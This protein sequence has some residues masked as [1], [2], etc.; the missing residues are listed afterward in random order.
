MSTERT[1]AKRAAAQRR[2]ADKRAAEKRAEDAARRRRRAVVGAVVAG[3]V[4]VVA[5][6]VVVIVQM[7][8]T[9]TSADGP[10]PAGLVADGTAFAVGPDGVP[11]VDVY[12]DFICP[13]CG[14]FAAL[15]GSTLASLAEDGA[16][17]VRYRPIAFLDRFSTD[18]YSTRALNAAAVVADAAGTEAF[19]RFHDALFAQ[20]PAEGGPGLSDDTLIE[21]ADDAGATGDDVA[22]AIRNLRFGDWVEQVTDAASKAGVNGTPTVLVDGEVLEDRSPQ[23]LTDAVAAAG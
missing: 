2:I 3:V 8:R 21:L 15:S 11:V 16:A 22:E 23:G 18:D 6:L 19:L 7:Q 14:Q 1:T 12:E 20:Q 4:V 9:S 17:Q 13:A 5:V 10:V